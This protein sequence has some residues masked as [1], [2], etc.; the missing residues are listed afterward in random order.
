MTLLGRSGQSCLLKID[1]TKEETISRTCIIAD[2]RFIRKTYA[3]DPADCSFKV[4]FLKYPFFLISL[5][6]ALPQLTVL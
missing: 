4:T 6:E 1:T 5:I 3:V 2:D